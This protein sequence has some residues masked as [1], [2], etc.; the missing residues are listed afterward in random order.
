MWSRQGKM[1][2][3]F[4]LFVLL[5]LYYSILDN[6]ISWI[7]SFALFSFF[8]MTLKEPLFHLQH[9]RT[10]S[11][12]LFLWCW[13]LWTLSS[14]LTGFNQQLILSCEYK[15]RKKSQLGCLK[16]AVLEIQCKHVIT[17]S[18]NVHFCFIFQG[19]FHLNTGKRTDFWMSRMKNLAQLCFLSV[20]GSAITMVG[21]LS[22]DLRRVVLGFLPIGGTKSHVRLWFK[23]KISVFFSVDY[24]W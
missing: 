23:M 6:N 24:Q 7:P 15:E 5:S 1:C 12:G 18:K 22:W 10:G 2:S 16:T 3:L 19:K 9:C 17:P 20:W 13:H 4:I 21:C 8:W 11:Q 14:W